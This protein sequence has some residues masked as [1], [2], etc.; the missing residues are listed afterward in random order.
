MLTLPLFVY[1]V[2]VVVAVVAIDLNFL[3]VVC[4]CCGGCCC[5]YCF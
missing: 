2:A 4:F 5:S 1:V 3:E